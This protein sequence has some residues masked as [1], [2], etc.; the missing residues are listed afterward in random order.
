MRTRPWARVVALG[1]RPYV[2]ERRW[3][4]AYARQIL[5]VAARLGTPFALVKSRVWGAVHAETTAQRVPSLGPTFNRW[6]YAY[7]ALT[8]TAVKQPGMP[9]ALARCLPS[10]AGHVLSPDDAVDSG[11]ARVDPDTVRMW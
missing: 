3:K 2:T 10:G 5:S 8:R 4:P 9:C 1:R 6:S 11:V 7:A